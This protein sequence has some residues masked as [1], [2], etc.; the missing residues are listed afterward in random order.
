LTRFRLLFVAFVFAALA[1]GL[2][3]CG[4]GDSGGSGENPQTVLDQTFSGDNEKV[5]SGDIDLSLK[6]STSGD[7]AGSFDASLSGPFENQGDKKVPKFDLNVTASG[8]GQGQDFNFDGGLT[9]TG[10]AAF[11]N[12]KGSDFQ[13]DQS[14]FDQFKSQVESATSTSNA[15]SGTEFFKQLGIDDPKSLLTNLSNDGTADIKG[16]ET[17]HVSGD[18]DVGKTV[19]AFKSLLGS[20]SLLQQLGGQSSSLPDPA[21]LDQVKQAVK[22]AHFDIY[23]GVDDHIL[24]G[25]TIA[26][27]IEPPSGSTSKVDIDFD[28]KVGALN[29]SQTIEAPSNPKSFGDLLSELGIPASAL[30]QLGALG[31]GAGQP[32]T[33]GTGNTSPVS[34]GGVDTQQAQK[35]LD[36]ISKANTAT[37]L[38]QC[39]SLA[40]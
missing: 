29:E 2:V 8:S 36:C 12:Y 10:D 39:Q 38:Q 15:Q 35:Y 32:S 27:S 22:N 5:N 3:A 26:L 40:P 30:G 24:R 7:Q 33:G 21:Q 14:I 9:S 17:N 31:L 11:V 34:P 25:L 1:T 6:V 23:S 37:D 19:D 13:V 28:F 18:L 4:G 16:T 20:A